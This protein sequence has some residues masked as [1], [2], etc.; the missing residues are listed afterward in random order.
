ME[1]L[2]NDHPD[3]LGEMHSGEFVVQRQ[4]GY[5]FAQ[6]A[7][8]QMIEQ[9][10]NCNSESKGRLT[11]FSVNKSAARSWT[12]TQHERDEISKQC[13]KLAGHKMLARTH[14]YLDE[15]RKKIQV[16]KGVRSVMDNIINPLDCHPYR[17]RESL[18]APGRNF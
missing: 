2:C 6:V 9:T 7:C 11:G 1:S 3:I 13:T 4:Q 12:L 14:V 8:D 18:S 16:E 15:S 17:L 5:G 10:T